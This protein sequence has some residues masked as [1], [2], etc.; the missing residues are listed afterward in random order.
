MTASVP[1]GFGI[2]LRHARMVRGM[3][4][5]QLGAQ[6]GLTQGYLSKIENDRAMPT[7]A[8]LHRIVQALGTNINA[9]LSDLDCLSGDLFVMRKR[10]RQKLVTGRRRPGNRVILEQ[11]VPSG[12]QFLMQANIHV[13]ERGGASKAPISHRGQEFGLVLSGRLELSVNGKHIELKEGDAFYFDSSLGHGYRNTGDTAARVLWVN[14]P[15]TF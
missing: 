5:E 14:T 8:T 4:L 15:P 3:S 12:P 1:P 13:I 9:L 7:V 6:V 10:N 2:K 11:L